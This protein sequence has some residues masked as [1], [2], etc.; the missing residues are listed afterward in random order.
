MARLCFCVRHTNYFILMV[1]TVYSHFARG[2]TAVGDKYIC[3]GMQNTC[4][5]L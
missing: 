5:S 3:V 4:N 1:S 2:I